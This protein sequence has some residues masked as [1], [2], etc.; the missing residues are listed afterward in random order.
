MSDY[1]AFMG[2]PRELALD[3]GKLQQ[4]YYEL[5][6]EYHPDFHT[7]G[8]EEARQQ[9]LE[10]AS[11]LNQAYRTLRD[12]YERARYL[13][14]LEWP[15]LPDAEKKRIPPAL[16]MEVMEMQEKVAEAQ[17]ADDPAQKERLNAELLDIEARLKVKMEGLREGLDRIATTWSALPDAGDDAARR[18]ALS[19]LNTLLNTRNYLRTLLATIDAAVRGGEGVRH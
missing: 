1:F 18:T 10:R 2:F 9:S 7:Q 4:R 14:D 5:S 17:F 16:L 11:L 13:L 19:E 6:R 12:P 15:D 3:E 8:D